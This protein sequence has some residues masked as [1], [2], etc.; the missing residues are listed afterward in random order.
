M[1]ACASTKD[2]DASEGGANWREAGDTKHGRRSKQGRSGPSED[3][4]TTA[5]AAPAATAAARGAEEEKVTASFRDET[6][7]LRTAA[8]PV[9]AACSSVGVCAQE[10]AAH[11]AC[12]LVAVARAHAAE[13][14]GSNTSDCEEST[15]RVNA[16]A[17]VGVATTRDAEEE[18]RVNAAADV[19]VA[20][21]RDAEEEARVN[22]AADVG[23]ATTRDAEEEARVN[24]AADVGVATTRDAE[25]E[26][27]VNAADDVG[28]A[29]TRDAEEEA[30]VNAADDV[31]VATTRDAEEEKATSSFRDDS[32]KPRASVAHAACVPVAVARA[33]AAEP[34]GNSTAGC[35][36]T[37]RVNNPCAA[38]AAGVPTTAAAARDAEE[39][40]T[41]TSFHDNTPRPAVGICAEESAAHAVCAP[42]ADGSSSTPACA[43]AA[44]VPTTAAAARDAEEEKAATSLRDE[45]DTR[46]RTASTSVSAACS[47]VGICAQEN[48]DVCVPAAD[49]NSSTPACAAAAG[50]PTTA[51]A[52][53]DA[54][55]ETA[56]T[57]FH[58]E[59]KKAPGTAQPAV[60]QDTSTSYPPIVNHSSA[61]CNKASGIALPAARQNTNTSQSPPVNHSSAPCSKA[62]GTA[63]PAVQQNTSTNYPPIVNHS[64]A[65]CKKASGIAR[66]AAQQ[67]N[68]TSRP[69]TVNHSSAPCSKAYGTA[70]PAIQQDNSTSYPPIVN[71]SSAVCNEASGNALPV[72]QRAG[73]NNGGQGALH[74]EADESVEKA[75]C[76]NN[77]GTSASSFVSVPAFPEDEGGLSARPVD[78]EDRAV[79]VFRRASDMQ[80][81]ES[82]SRRSLVSCIPL[83]VSAAQMF[84]AMGSTYHTFGEGESVGRT[85]TSQ[86]QLTHDAVLP[87]RASPEPAEEATRDNNN[88]NGTS[89]SSFVSVLALPEDEGAAPAVAGL[90]GFG[91]GHSADSEDRAV[92]ASDMRSVESDGRRS[93]ASCIP[94]V[95]TS[96]A[97]MFDALGNTHA[98]TTGEGESVGR[99]RTSQKQLMYDAV[100]APRAS[101][102]PAEEATRDNNNNNNN[103]TSTCSFVSV[104]ALPEDAGAA[105]AVAGLCGSGDGH[106]ARPVDSEDR[107]VPVFRRAS[108]MRSVESDGRRSMAS[109][110]PVVTTSAAQMFDAVGNTHTHTFGEGESVGRTRTSQKQLMYDMMLPPR[111]SRGFSREWS[112]EQV[113]QTDVHMDPTYWLDALPQTPVDQTRLAS[114]RSVRSNPAAQFPSRDC[115]PA[116]VYCGGGA[117]PSEPA[118]DAAPESPLAAPS[119]LATVHPPKAAAKGAGLS[120]SD[121]LQNADADYFEASSDDDSCCGDLPPPMQSDTADR[122]SRSIPS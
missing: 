122:G 28:V 30:R 71:I 48:V 82:D 117:S 46:P 34:T 121:V 99:T 39:E 41:T 42:A 96:A 55:E 12:V 88:N 120:K 50:A 27:R 113:T 54:E 16:A 66:P 86:K 119:S 5:A 89:T 68:N 80:S 13:P 69:P 63:Q 93:M 53:R 97:Q 70:R 84:D 78:S 47:S 72:E 15:T 43:A 95:T 116:H 107:A 57:S 90:C 52:A 33:H 91:D 105:P 19:G 85:R 75:A 92:R 65:P 58:D 118:T 17:D 45:N 37:T 114:L 38:A 115:L 94:V 111:G 8:T 11:A 106:S 40:N 64:S 74:S 102:E 14:T 44:G 23:V 62:S 7:T 100:L 59:N 4:D 83:A 20:T 110:I 104:P 81:V 49:A 35:E 22:A 29:T 60:Q 67:N 2:D 73:A 26:T 76:K 24:A 31:G 18:A 101:P 25:E 36:S 98:H 10:G 87:P 3:T 6:N 109:C 56:T 51:A 32:N 112:R 61:P 21:T 103:G 108:D 9:S 79:P 1:G 77:H